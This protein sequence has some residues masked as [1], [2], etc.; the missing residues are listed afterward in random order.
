MAA[1]LSRRC[2][3]YRV[4]EIAGALG[5]GTHGGVVAAIRRIEN[6]PRRTQATLRKLEKAIADA[7][8]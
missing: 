5:Y 3:G 2:F 1:Y 4:G 6:A 7:N 8:N